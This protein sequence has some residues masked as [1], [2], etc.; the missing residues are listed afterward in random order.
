MRGYLQI[1]GVIFGVIA[2]LHVLRLL[3]EWQAQ[4]AG[5]AVPLWISWVAIFAAGTLSF[6]AFRLLGQAQPSR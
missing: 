4:V 1:S 2:L 3:L 6:W 5:W